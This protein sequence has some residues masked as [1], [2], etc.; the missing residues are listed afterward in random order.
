M[1]YD[2]ELPDLNEIPRERWA[3][4]LRPL[5]DRDRR[6]AAGKVR[7]QDALMAALELVGYMLIEDPVVPP[8]GVPTPDLPQAPSAEKPQRARQVNFRLSAEQY[9]RLERL[10][11]ALELA[12]AALA[13]LMVVRGVDAELRKG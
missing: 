1:L 13:R 5:E 10:A 4:T 6:R 2:H 8:L 3:E 11:R 12:P 9:E 7:G